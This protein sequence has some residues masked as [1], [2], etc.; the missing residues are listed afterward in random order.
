MLLQ[1]DDR[2]ERLAEDIIS[3]FNGREVEGKGLIAV[4]TR[5]NAAKLYTAMKKKKECPEIDIVLSSYEGLDID[6]RGVSKIEEE[7]KKCDS[8]LKLVIVCDMWLTGFDVEHLHTLYLDKLLKNHSLLQAIA[9]VN[10]VFSGKGP[11]MVVDYV[12]VTRELKQSVGQYIGG[13]ETDAIGE[14]KDLEEKMKAKYNSI[15][16]F[17]GV[18]K[19]DGIGTEEFLKLKEFIVT[20]QV[21]N[22]ISKERKKEFLDI[23]LVFLKAHKVLMPLKV[24]ILWQ[25]RQK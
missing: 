14:M 8:S 6:D 2:V 20:D 1:A 4:S 18:R 19:L 21:H 3:H 9:R 25:K 10:R 24:R 13:R 7:F 5:K 22:G 15:L 16:S 11:G 23:A 17:L 12:G